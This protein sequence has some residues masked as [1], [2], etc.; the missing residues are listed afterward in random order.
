MVA[1][2]RLLVL[3]LLATAMLLGAFRVETGQQKSPPHRS[4]Q[5]SIQRN[6]AQDL[7]DDEDGARQLFLLG[8]EAVSPLIR[9]LSGP[10]KE[11]RASAAK[12][13][14]Y[15]GNAGEM[16]TLRTACQ[17][18]RDEEGKAVMSCV[19]AGR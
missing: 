5:D 6:L 9:F 17:C 14:A 10:N 1:T 2:N 8:D 15:I 18:V 7:D 13:L 19:I 16:R 3:P 12:A 11:K 4:I